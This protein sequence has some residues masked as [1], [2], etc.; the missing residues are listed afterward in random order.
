MENLSCQDPQHLYFADKEGYLYY[1]SLSQNKVVQELGRLTYGII[2]CMAT[3]HDDKSLLIADNYGYVKQITVNGQRVLKDF[4][5]IHN[6]VVKSITVTSD[7]QFVFTSDCDGTLKQSDLHTGKLVHD[8]GR[9]HQGYIHN[10]VATNTMK[11][12]IMTGHNL[13]LQFRDDEIFGSHSK[14]MN[15]ALPAIKLE[16]YNNTNRQYKPKK[17]TISG[18]LVSEYNEEEMEAASSKY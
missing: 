7:S 18:E 2:S 4:G 13:Y 1:Y 14:V 6:S 9:I 5:K 11:G 12:T 16:I 3:T 10:I 8:Y 15:K 17:V